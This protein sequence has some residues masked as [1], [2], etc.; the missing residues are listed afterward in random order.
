MTIRWLKFKQNQDGTQDIHQLDGWESGAF[1][2]ATVEE[3]PSPEEHRNNCKEFGLIALI[4]LQGMSQ[5][6]ILADTRTEQA[7]EYAYTPG[8]NPSDFGITVL[9]TYQDICDG[10]LKIH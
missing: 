5:E 3:N 6:E 9:E 10:T 1:P 4:M 7:F 2:S 8:C